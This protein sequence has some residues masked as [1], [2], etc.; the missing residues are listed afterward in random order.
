MEDDQKN[1]QSV[2]YS[3]DQQ[4][5]LL[6]FSKLE[7][8]SGTVGL[9]GDTRCMKLACAESEVELEKRLIAASLFFQN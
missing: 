6:V 2:T 7:T 8:V 5:S 4:I 3:V 9:K 1:L